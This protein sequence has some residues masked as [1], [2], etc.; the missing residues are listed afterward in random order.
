MEAES[1]RCQQGAAERGYCRVAL[2][3][4]CMTG[5]HRFKCAALGLAC[6]HRG[7]IMGSSYNSALAQFSR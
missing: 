5:S 6:S 2:L 3:F 7:P 1:E 4:A